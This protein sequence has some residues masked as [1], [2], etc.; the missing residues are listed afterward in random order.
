[1]L[2]ISSEIGE[3]IRVCDRAYVM[4]DKTIAGHLERGDLDEAKLVRLAVHRD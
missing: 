2:M 3:I 4:K 1:M